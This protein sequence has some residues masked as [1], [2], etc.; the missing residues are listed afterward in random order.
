MV[1]R[2]TSAC[3][4]HLLAHDGVLRVALQGCVLPMALVHQA[5]RSGALHGDPLSDLH[6]K[7]L[8]GSTIEPKLRAGV[9]W[10][11]AAQGVL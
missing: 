2:W 5:L 11:G 4:A 8:E 7:M 1:L 3:M 10:L 9:W 6:S